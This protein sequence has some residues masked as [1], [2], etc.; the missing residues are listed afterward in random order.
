MERCTFSPRRG[1]INRE[2]FI[3][4]A[5]GQT[6][7]RIATQIASIL[8]GKTKPMFAPHIDVGDFVI[9]VNAE[10]IKVTGRKAQQKVYRHHTGFIGG[11]TERPFYE[12]IVDNPEEIIEL[13]VR[14]MLPKTKLG[15][16]MFDKL[17]VYRGP[18]HPHSA[19]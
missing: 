7:G 8:R 1:D 18:N 6:L 10:K 19:Q 16:H 17:K 2:W 14:R 11:L 13:A 3:V 9:V 4:D 5:E 12:M 15:R